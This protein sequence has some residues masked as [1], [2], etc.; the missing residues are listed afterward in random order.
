MS[1]L[2]VGKLN[3]TTGVQLPSF[4]TANLPST[5]INAGFMAFDSTDGVVK[6]F[7]GERWQ[8]LT[9]ASMTASGG[10][11]VYDTGNFRVHKFLNSGTFQVTDADGAAKMDIMIIG[12]GG[13][14]GCSDGNC[15]NGGGVAGGCV[16]KSGITPYKGTFPVVI[17]AGGQGYNNTD[18]QGDDGGDSSFFGY[19]GLGGGGGAAGGGVDGGR[20]RN[21]GCGG[22][23]SHPYSGPRSTGLQPTSTSGGFGFGGGAANNSSPDWG[24]GA[25]GGIGQ[26]GQDG[27]APVGGYG[28]DGKLFD[29]DGIQKWYGGGGAGANCDNPNASIN[30]GGLGGGGYAAANIY[31]NGGN[32]YGGGGGGA[33]YPNRQAGRGG[34]GVVI[35]R[36]P[37]ATGDATVGQS[38]GNPAQNAAHILSVNASAGDG[39]Y[40]IKPAGYTGAAQQVYC[41]MSG[42]GWM[43]V[44]S[45]DAGSTVIPSGTSRNNLAYTLSRNGT[46]GHLGTPSPDEDYIM[47]VMID[48]LNFQS[49]RVVGFG[50][51]STNNTYSWSNWGTYVD[52]QWLLY[53]SGSERRTTDVCPRSQVSV[54]G[55][56]S[57]SAGYFGLDGVAHDSGLNANS[58]Q[59]TVGGVGT[60]GNAADPSS[61]CY[62]GH[63]SS[64]GQ[65]EGWYSNSGNHNAQG[66]TT[67]VK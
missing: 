25:G 30:P 11:E 13:G 41:W 8:K 28:G 60:A 46:Q 19:I 44:A 33:G 34:N 54:T 15:S 66:Y 18:R 21:G 48:S 27:T 47:G 4:T 57:G 63:G 16:F 3:A 7:N 31:G 14:G 62:L 64:E 43:L 32:G 1:E 58:N 24:G 51:D 39:T 20:G 37:V 22:G 35:V 49:V 29:I 26:Q 65:F 17:G 56:L 23:G 42:G 55:E 59:T 52:V 10:D 6:V 61:G 9:D 67:W 38:S 50:R 53:T 5:G 45:N 2:N 40:W 12:G 36:Y